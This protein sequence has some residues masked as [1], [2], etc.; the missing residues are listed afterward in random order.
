MDDGGY[1]GTPSLPLCIWLPCRPRKLEMGFLD[2]LPLRPLCADSHRHL[3]ERIVSEKKK[4]Y[5]YP[6]TKHCFT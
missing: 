3:H 5:D 2:R 6:L 1:F 4:V